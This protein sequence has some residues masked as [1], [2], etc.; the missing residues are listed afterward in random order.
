MLLVEAILAIRG[1][2]IADW[3]AIYVNVPSRQLT[4]KVPDRTVVKPNDTERRVTAPDGLQVRNKTLDDEKI[5]DE[6]CFFSSFYLIL[7]K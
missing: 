7:Q 3:N 5:S 2:T 4:V 6:K 1:W